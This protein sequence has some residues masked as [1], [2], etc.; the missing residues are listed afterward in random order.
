MAKIPGKLGKLGSIKTLVSLGLIA[1][2]LGVAIW[3]IVSHALG[4]ARAGI[5][6]QN[7]TGA[8]QLAPPVSPLLFGTN[9]GLFDSNDQVL[10]SPTR[11]T[12]LKKMIVRY[13]VMP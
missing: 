7:N 5:E 10:N 11:G 4:G 12:Q 3:G 1:T 6:Q 13:F 2:I 8:V 9:M